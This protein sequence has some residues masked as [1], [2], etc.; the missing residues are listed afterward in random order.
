MSK[1]GA[2]DDG[3]NDDGMSPFDL[4]EFPAFPDLTIPFLG[5]IQL[6]GRVGHRNEQMSRLRP[7]HKIFDSTFF[8]QLHGRRRYIQS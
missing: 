2:A 7:G 3:V 1:P 5:G 4:E 6:Q 8:M